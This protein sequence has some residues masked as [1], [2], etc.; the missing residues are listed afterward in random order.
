MMKTPDGLS[1]GSAARDA[2][3]PK[4]SI[5][6]WSVLAGRGADAASGYQPKIRTWSEYRARMCIE[7]SY[8]TGR[9]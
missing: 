4:M 9:R 1:G 5:A 6:C 3:A 2:P 7:A 8:P